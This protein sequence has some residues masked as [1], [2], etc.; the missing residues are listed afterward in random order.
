MITVTASLTCNRKYLNPTT[1]MVL[2]IN[3]EGFERDHCWV[4]INDELEIALKG[5][6]RNHSRRCTFEAKVKNY[7]KPLDGVHQKTLYKIKNLNFL[8]HANPKKRKKF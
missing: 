8:E 4:K 6:Y 5:I 7:Y 1:T 3:I 2:L